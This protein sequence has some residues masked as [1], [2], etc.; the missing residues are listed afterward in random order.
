MKILFIAFDSGE[1]SVR[2]A[3]ALAQEVE[4]CFMLPQKQAEP[5]LQWLNPALNFQ[6]FAKPR[7]RQPVN[8][9]RTIYMLLQRIKRF[10]PDVIHF[11]KGHLWF[12]LALT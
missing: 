9:I 7:L 5:Y 8:Q 3:S 12:N 4:V 1:L 6:P 2:L 11:Q 10:N